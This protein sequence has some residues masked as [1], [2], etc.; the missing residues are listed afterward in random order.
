M[1]TVLTKLLFEWCR[2]QANISI[3]IT[4]IIVFQ[5]VASSRTTN[6]TVV[7]NIL[8]AGPDWDQ[9][10]SSSDVV[11]HDSLCHRINDTH[12]CKAPSYDDGLNSTCC[13]IMPFSPSMRGIVCM[14]TSIFCSFIKQKNY[15]STFRLY[16]K[17]SEGGR[18][19]LYE[20][21][22][23]CASV[24][25]YFL[26]HTFPLLTLTHYEEKII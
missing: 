21:R 8:P 24:W 9:Y 25:C 2:W 7:I 6:I 18:Y 19:S 16:D 10:R 23:K 3:Y 11:G 5:H 22:E 15:Y 26:S 1:Q 17:I 4:V 13:P 12:R 14:S 20:G